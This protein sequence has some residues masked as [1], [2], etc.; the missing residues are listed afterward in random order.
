MD[1]EDSDKVEA[2][3]KENKWQVGFGFVHES[4]RYYPNGPLL[5]NVLGFVGIDDIGLSGMEKSMESY[6]GGEKSQYKVITDAKGN[7]ILR[8]SVNQKEP[9]EKGQFI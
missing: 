1:P 3:L 8:S 7:P 5:A 2:L 9:E 4:R 6:I